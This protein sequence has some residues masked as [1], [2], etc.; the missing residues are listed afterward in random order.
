VDIQIKKKYSPG[1]AKAQ[2]QYDLIK[3]YDFSIAGNSEICERSLDFYCDL[4]AKFGAL[5]H[6]KED[7]MKIMWKDYKK[8]PKGPA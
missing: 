7:L 3:S 1:V 5:K 6:S 2:F 8:L 4:G